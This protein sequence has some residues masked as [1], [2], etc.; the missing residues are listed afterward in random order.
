MH[1]L[2]Q[3]LCIDLTTTWVAA[4]YMYVLATV[5]FTSGVDLSLFRDTRTG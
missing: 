2:M 1:E 4:S 3:A 5:G